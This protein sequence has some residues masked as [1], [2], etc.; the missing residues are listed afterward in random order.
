MIDE[1]LWKLQQIYEFGIRGVP[2]KAINKKFMK[3][4]NLFLVKLRVK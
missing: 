2:I 4:L 3:G 1:K